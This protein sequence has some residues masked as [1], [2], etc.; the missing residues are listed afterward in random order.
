MTRVLILAGDA[1]EALELFYPYY[2]LKEEGFE[3]E[4]AGP[5]K[6]VL[7]T[8][9]H[10]FE[11]GWTT[12]TEKKGY[13]FIWIDKK[14]SEVDP[15][16]YDGLVIPGGRMPEYIRLDNDVERIVKDFFE[17]NKPVAAICHGALLLTFL[18]VQLT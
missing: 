14:F 6:D 18:G 10:D 15:E 7:Y 8:V 11:P 12:Y 16:E 13:R 1:V 4:V 17:K 5:K 3:V 9:V 2:R